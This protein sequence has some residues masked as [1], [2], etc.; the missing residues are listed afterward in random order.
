[1]AKT[2]LPPEVISLVHNVEL[3]KSGW[4]D[5]ALDRLLLATVW[6]CGEPPNLQEL[7]SSFTKNF[8]V[9][10]DTERI[11]RHIESLCG[12][13]TLV[14]LPGGQYKLPESSVQDFLRDLE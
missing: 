11:L 3:N 12:A 6:L 7:L 13:G 4:W 1:M 5:R 14:E 10:S 2:A 9:P 8:G